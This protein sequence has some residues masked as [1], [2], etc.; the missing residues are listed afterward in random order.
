M[1]IFILNQD[2]RLAAQDMCDKHVPKMIVES[3]QMMASALL[4]HGAHPDDMP[5]TKK[6]TPYK[7]GYPHHPCTKWVGDSRDNY[8]WLCEH[9]HALLIEY[10]TR[11]KKEHACSGPLMQM[12]N[13]EEFIPEGPLTQFAL[14]MPEQFRN[15]D[16]VYAYRE[17]Y[18]H[19]ADTMTV[20]W[21]RAGKEPTWWTI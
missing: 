17:Y 18:R 10:W 7:G 4:R 11:F 13:M 20:E 16:A 5:L 12:Y 21:T 1:N 9:S 2:P 19:K 15:L 8:D 6:G 3:A 14:A